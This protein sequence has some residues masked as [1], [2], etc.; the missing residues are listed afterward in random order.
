MSSDEVVREQLLQ[1][2]AGG[3]AHWTFDKIIEGFPP[4]H[5]NAQ[6]PNVPYSP[7]H[8]LEHIR[9]AQSDI[10]EF[11]RDL[12]HVSPKWP[13]GYWP[14]KGEEADQARWE[15]TI[16]SLRSD[17]VD[18]EAIVQDPATDLYVDLPHAEGFSILRE[19]LLVADHNSHHLGEFAILRQVMGTWAS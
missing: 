3:N 14:P 6:P 13:E 19:M 9:I 15:Q 16:Q 18:L 2:L 1:L 11:I 4:D 17:M 12:D 5:F 10:L 7:W 8:I